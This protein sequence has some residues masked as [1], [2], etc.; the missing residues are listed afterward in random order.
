MENTNK[1]SSHAVFSI[2]L[3][4]VFVTKY[5]RKALTPELLEFLKTSFEEILKSWRCTLL[6]F[7]GE[8]DHVHLLVDIHP[9]LDISTLINNLKSA[10]ARKARNEFAVHLAKFY[11]KPLFWHRAYYVG[12]VGGA[13]LETVKAYVEA[14]GTIE[15]KRKSQ[16][17]RPKATS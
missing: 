6:E 11:W 10:S 12:S 8:E 14:Q 15:H 4:I 7:R 16:A 13:T 3:H 9:A 5:R 1:S 17:K 2:K